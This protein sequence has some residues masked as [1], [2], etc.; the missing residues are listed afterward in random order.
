MKEKLISLVLPSVWWWF[1]LLP[2]QHP[3]LAFLFNGIRYPFE[4]ILQQVD[5]ELQFETDT[6][7]TWLLILLSGILGTISSFFLAN[8]VNRSPEYWLRLTRFSLSVVI[9]Y[10]L[11]IYGWSKVN[12]TQ[13]YLP[14]PNTLYTPFGKLSKD[15]AFW[16][17]IGASYPVSLV[18]GL[19][20]VLIAIGLLF[21][22]TRFISALLASCSFALIFGINCVFDISVK[23][24]SGSLLLFSLILC[25]SYRENW[26]FLLRIKTTEKHAFIQLLPLTIV[27]LL[28]IIPQLLSKPIQDDRAFRI[29]IHGAF[30]TINNSPIQQVFIHRSGYLILMDQQG[31]M[32]DFPIRRENKH[33]TFTY[34]EKTGKLSVSNDTLSIQIHQT[35]WRFTRI[36]YRT[37]PLLQDDFHWTAD[38]F[39]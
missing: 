12:K 33:F 21:N 25:L 22:R 18:T 32:Y 11:M 14:E 13:F 26:R 28:T 2:F 36:P 9:A 38:D 8:K 34:Q 3:V 27:A 24:L 4:Q 35:T 30:K 7:G 5:P 37:L 31:E 23:A 10:F 16:S 15:L 39:H 20:E 1:L 19:C 29:S 17:L 6:M